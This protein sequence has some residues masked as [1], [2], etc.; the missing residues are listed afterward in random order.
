MALPEQIQKQIEAA[1][2]LEKAVYTETPAGDPPAPP[3]PPAAETPEL[4]APPA[5]K[6][7]PP[8]AA[9]D[10]DGTWEQ[11]FKVLKG[12]YDAEVPRLHAQLRDNDA[13]V[14]EMAQ[15]M[16]QLQRQMQ[17]ITS[18]PDVTGDFSAAASGVEIN[19]NEREEYGDE[20]LDIVGR[21]ALQVLLPQ[22][23]KVD[24]KIEELRRSLVGVSHEVT[25]S[26][27]DKFLQGL[28]SAH[29]SWRTLNVDEGFK[30][31]L[32]QPDP[33]SGILRKDLLADAVNAHSVERAV[34]FFRAYESEHG[35]QP[36]PKP[37]APA[38]RERQPETDLAAFAAPGR[39]TPGSAPAPSNQLPDVWSKRDIQAFYR[40]VNKGGY[41]GREA[42]VER[43]ERSITA[44]AAAGRI[45]A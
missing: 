41:Q 2:E 35:V 39:G 15:R 8:P 16:E 38:P 14:A 37:P 7:A 5:P 1:A 17:Q 44:A 24:A 33:L 29:N 3:A 4:P 23:A 36:K 10:E 28:D 9:N 43:I 26:A 21:R 6:P 45:T 25:L 27:H 20:L 31:W 18:V 22:I 19:D 34:N 13:T 42:E 32:A 40:E 12:K 11:R 30:G